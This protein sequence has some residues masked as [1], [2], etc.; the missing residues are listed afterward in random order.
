MGKNFYQ[1]QREGH[2]WFKEFRYRAV[3]NC[4]KG[5]DHIKSA[6]QALWYEGAVKVTFAQDWV[7]SQP[8]FSDIS[9]KHQQMIQF[10][11]ELTSAATVIGLYKKKAAN[12]EI[13]AIS[14]IAV[15]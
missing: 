3:Y 1:L 13:I 8:F 12:R 10:Q 2:G 4:A 9:L 6:W 15:S 11:A 5:Y 7:L 14:V